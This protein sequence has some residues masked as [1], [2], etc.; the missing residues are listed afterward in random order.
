MVGDL[1]VSGE[2][3]CLRVLFK[4]VLEC[5]LAS[6][7]VSGLRV[8]VTKGG[9]RAL[10]GLPLILLRG[11]FVDF[12]MLQDFGLFHKLVGFTVDGCW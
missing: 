7:R 1:V 9:G 10:E 8:G 6:L 11:G 4:D 2:L 3:R 5:F 12:G